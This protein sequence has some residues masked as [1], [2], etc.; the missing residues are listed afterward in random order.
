MTEVENTID[1]YIQNINDKNYEEYLDN[2]KKLLEDRKKCLKSKKCIYDFTITDK[3]IIK[4]KG[5][6]EV[7]NLKLPKYVL[8][9]DRLE[10]IN[11]ELKEITEKIKFLQNVINLESDKKM[12]DDYKK[13]RKDYIELEKEGN[14]LNEYLL[15]VNKVEDKEK[16]QLELKNEIQKLETEKK[17]QYS[18]ISM[19]ELTKNDKGFSHENYETL[20]KKYLDNKELDKLKTELKISKSLS[21][22][23]DDLFYNQDRN[24]F[25]GK[26]NYMITELPNVNKK[27]K[28]IIKKSVSKSVTKSVTKK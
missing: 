9:E 16:R 28:K 6:T 22:R 12:I 20:I 3:N 11:V 25:M 8:V 26:I 19:M 14:M 21:L 13:L 17:K 18:E 10:E 15:K 4:K 24:N 1:S 5:E 7:F 23:T 2:Y 27:T